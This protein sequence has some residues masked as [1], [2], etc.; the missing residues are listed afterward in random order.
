MM[1]ARLVE[2][3]LVEINGKTYDYDVLI[4]R[5]RSRAAARRPRSRS[6]TGTVTPR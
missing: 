2:F 5:G 3:G 4:E 1:K 6:V